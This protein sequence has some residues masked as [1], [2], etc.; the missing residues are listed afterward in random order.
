MHAPVWA[1]LGAGCA[2]W[3]ESLSSLI[4][5]DRLIRGESCCV[6][7]ATDRVSVSPL[8][9]SLHAGGKGVQARA[10]EGVPGK[11]GEAIFREA[12]GA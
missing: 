9:L 8:N 11:E 10:E 1:M 2:A 3:P 7:I 6:S 12:E 5:P 4:V